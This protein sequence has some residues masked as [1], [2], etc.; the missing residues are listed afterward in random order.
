M[1]GRKSKVEIAMQ[2]VP[3]VQSPAER[4]E[5]SSDEPRGTKK[6]ANWWRQMVRKERLQEASAIGENVGITRSEVV[7]L[8]LW[9]G[10]VELRALAV[11]DQAAELGRLKQ[12]R[13]AE[14]T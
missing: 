11:E 5:R 9:R 12:R 13:L 10:L 14:K 4:L 2:E 1:F 7:D 3:E 8:L 6:S